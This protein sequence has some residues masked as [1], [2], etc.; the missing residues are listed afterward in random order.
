MS[1]PLEICVLTL[2]T[3]IMKRLWLSYGW[4][5]MLIFLPLKSL[6]VFEVHLN[7]SEDVAAPVLHSRRYHTAVDE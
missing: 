5:G 6:E 3:Q 2:R 4:Y 7:Q 1:K